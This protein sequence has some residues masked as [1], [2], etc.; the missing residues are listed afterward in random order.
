[1]PGGPCTIQ[2]E[3]A[4]PMASSVSDLRLA[5]AQTQ[6][7]QRRRISRYMRGESTVK[8]APIE[9]IPTIHGHLHDVGE[10]EDEIRASWDFVC[11]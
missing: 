9:L 8:F 4:R 6:R 5:S 3:R 7:R 11:T 10:N 1:M 2:S